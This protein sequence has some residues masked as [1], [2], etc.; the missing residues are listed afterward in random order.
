[1]PPLHMV[2]KV[3]GR[4]ALPSEHALCVHQLRGS[5]AVQLR[6]VATHGVGQG[7]GTH[8]PH[9]HAG[10]EPVGASVK[11]RGEEAAHF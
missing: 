5:H 2:G 7:V 11:S 8:G 4:V 3:E 1:M 6:V 10:P 9:A